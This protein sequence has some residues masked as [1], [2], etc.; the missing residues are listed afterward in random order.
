MYCRYQFPWTGI[1]L[2]QERT[3]K[4]QDAVDEEET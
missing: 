4:E 2:R 3:R 1:Y